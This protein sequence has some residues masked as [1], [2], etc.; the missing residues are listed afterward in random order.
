MFWLGLFAALGVGACFGLWSI[1]LADGLRCRT[2]GYPDAR[3]A[4]VCPAYFGN[5]AWFSLPFGRLA[6]GAPDRWATAGMMMIGALAWGFTWWMYWHVEA[7]LA[8]WA[9]NTLFASWL[10]FL[11]VLDYRWRILPIELMM[12]AGFV[13][14]LVR[15]L[16]FDDPVVSL[17]KGALFMGGFFG[18]QTWLSR[19]QWL[20][21]G[22]PVMA[23]MIGVM[24]GWPVA[25]S[26][27]YFTYMA[28]IPLLLIQVIRVG[29]VRRVRWPFGPLLAFG[30]II[31]LRYGEM[32]YRF[33]LYSF[34]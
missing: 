5:R 17:V 15:W 28:V 22:D 30:G 12:G 1:V 24:I 8:T 21:A 9:W 20:G 7:S 19:G 29:A 11:G 27:V 16:G 14:F 2:D 3:E 33:F 18:L 23:A 32:L 26:S 10:L 6:P 13:G 4:V 31:S 25:M 34:G